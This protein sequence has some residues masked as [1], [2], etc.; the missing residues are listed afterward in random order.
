MMRMSARA[1]IACV[2]AAALALGGAAPAPG[3]ALADSG[4]FVLRTVRVA[5]AAHRYT[6]WRPPG[7]ARRRNLPAILFLHGSGQCGDDGAKGATIGLADALRAHPERWPFVVVFPQKPSE[8]IEWEECE[9]LVFAALDD[10]VRHAGVDPARVALAGLSQGGHGVWM[11]GARHPER[12]RCL[13]PVCGYGRARTVQRRAVQLPVWAFHG[14]R[15]DVVDPG[16]TRRIVEGLRRQRA[17]RGLDTTAV[18]MTLFPD[19]DHD[20]WDAAFAVDSLPAWIGERL[21]PR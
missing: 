14:L 13:V 6:V 9:D 20:S 12:W 3:A 11:L 18:R 5:N 21:R 4:A 19:A 7:D 15:D 10:A 17:L 2:L 8:D 16:D 1:F